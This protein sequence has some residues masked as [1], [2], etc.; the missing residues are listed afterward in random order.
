V[1][2]VEAASNWEDLEDR[3]AEAVKVAG[4]WINASGHY[5]CPS[6]LAALA[7]FEGEEE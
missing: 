4:G 2:H 3:A 5:P 1:Y 7:A 6:K